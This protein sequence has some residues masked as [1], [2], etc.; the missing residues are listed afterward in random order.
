ML[1][2]MA[3]LEEATVEP[4]RKLE[5]EMATGTIAFWT[6]LLGEM[7]V[8][9]GKGSTTEKAIGALDP[10]GVCTTREVFPGTALDATL[11]V[12]VT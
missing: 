10:P 3:G 8:I 4:A 1:T 9:V 6:P 7:E 11:N 12:A 2:E 5:P